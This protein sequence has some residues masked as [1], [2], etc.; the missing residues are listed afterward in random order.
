MNDCDVQYSESHMKI[1][2]NH[3]YVLVAH[4]D[5]LQILQT[6]FAAEIDFD[7]RKHRSLPHLG[8]AEV[9]EMRVTDRI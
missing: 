9:R 5:T 2:A 8:N 7:A 1:L 4:G 3:I 6:A